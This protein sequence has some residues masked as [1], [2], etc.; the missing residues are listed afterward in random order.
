MT[1]A[2]AAMAMGESPNIG[3]ALVA[4]DV[5]CMHACIS[6]QSNSC[7][8]SP[9]KAEAGTLF[10]YQKKYQSKVGVQV[11]CHTA[12]AND[13]GVRNGKLP[14]VDRWVLLPVGNVLLKVPATYGL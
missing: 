10:H 12:C 1:S 4:E 9:Q 13:Q 11:G 14:P 7:V 2:A 5:A 6:E 3:L 8:L